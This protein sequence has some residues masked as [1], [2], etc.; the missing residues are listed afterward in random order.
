MF[1]TLTA[2]E[3]FYFLYQGTDDLE[4]ISD[5]ILCPNLFQVYQDDLPPLDPPTGLTAESLLEGRIKLTWNAVASIRQE[6]SQEAISA[7]GAQ[8]EALSDAL[9]PDAPSDLVLDLVSQ[10]T[11]HFTLRDTSG[12]GHDNILK[13]HR[14]DY[15]NSCFN[16]L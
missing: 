15:E 1:Y 9:A 3:T 4:N 7:P 6:N 2:A 5:R 11:S 16:G 13:T 10:H 14:F 8:E 12:S